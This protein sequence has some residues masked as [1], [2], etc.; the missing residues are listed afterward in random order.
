M[1]NVPSTA[2]DLSDNYKELGLYIGLGHVDEGNPPPVTPVEVFAAGYERQNPNW[3]SV[4]GGV[5]QGD[6]LTFSNLPSGYYTYMTV[7][8]G[9]TAG[10]DD[11]I[12]WCE[13]DSSLTLDGQQIVV[14]P[15]FTQ[16]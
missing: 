15:V 8:A 5:I 9:P 1:V 11:L 7:Y 16:T 3:R 4:G 2:Q 10:S 12:D 6:P 14:T 13:I